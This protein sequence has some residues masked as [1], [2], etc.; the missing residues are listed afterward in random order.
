[1]SGDR[2]DR[3]ERDGL[4]EVVVPGIARR[5]QGCAPL[6]PDRARHQRPHR[7]ERPDA[8]GVAELPGLG[9]ADALP[10]VRVAGREGLLASEHEAPFVVGIRRLQP[11]P[12]AIEQ[13]RLPA[14]RRRRPREG[15][16][17]VAAVVVDQ[18]D[19]ARRTRVVVDPG[20]HAQ[21][22]LVRNLDPVVVD[23]E[24]ERRNVDFAGAGRHRFGDEVAA[25][26]VLQLVG[27]NDHPLAVDPVDPHPLDAVLVDPAQLVVDAL[28]FGEQHQ[29]AGQ[30]LQ[31]VGRR[32][33]DGRAQRRV[34]GEEADVAGDAVDCA[35][36]RLAPA[37][38][39]AL[40]RLAG[41]GNPAVDPVGGEV[42]GDADQQPGDRQPDQ[43]QQAEEARSVH[44][45]AAGDARAPILRPSLPAIEA[46]LFARDQ[47]QRENPAPARLPRA[48][49]TAG[50][51]GALRLQRRR[52]T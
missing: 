29:A 41:Q 3:D 4:P 44:R 34:R 19:P 48:A 26:L 5:A 36:D 16:E 15:V 10:R 51:R 33:R 39:R 50:D 20:A 27:G 9:R 8:V 25:R 7:R 30:F 6:A 12:V 28:G 22:R 32:P 35:D 49:V 21:R 1:M 2:R 24:V 31:R 17:Q 42:P 23:V 47:G 38:D 45:I 46:Q 14:R 43:Q 13:H 40:L 52:P 37:G 11:V 18:H